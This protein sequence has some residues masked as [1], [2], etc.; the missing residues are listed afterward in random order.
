MWPPSWLSSPR[1]RRIATA[2]RSPSSR[3]FSCSSF[4]DIQTLLSDDQ[5]EPRSGSTPRSPSIFHRVRVS[6]SVLR[7]WAQAQAHR[8]VDVQPPPGKHPCGSDL[9]VVLYFTSLRV[10]RKTFE[11]CRA[12]RSILRGFRVAIDERDLSMD[13]S[14][15]GELQGIVGRKKVSLPCVFVGGRLVGGLEEVRQ[16]HESGE[17]K[18]MIAGMPAAAS[19]ACDACGGLRFAVCEECSGS[20]K[21]YS[22][23][24]TGF[25]TCPACNANGL[26]RCP[27][28]TPPCFRSFKP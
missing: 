10:V 14:Y 16:L 15:L 23:K 6:A 11:D 21:I 2:P 3:S 12:V 5:P 19:A 27:S 1:T 13:A 7:A 24:T 9:T 22:E 17:L 4:K 20:H 18:R 26:I 8:G 28:C 25:R